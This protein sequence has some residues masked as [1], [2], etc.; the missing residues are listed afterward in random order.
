MPLYRQTYEHLSGEQKMVDVEASRPCAARDAAGNHF[1]AWLS[2]EGRSSDGWRLLSQEI[3]PD[4]PPAAAP[5]SFP[6]N[7]VLREGGQ[8]PRRV[9]QTT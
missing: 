3:V 9:V 6:P 2:G 8:L 7:R 4:E 1:N 5:P